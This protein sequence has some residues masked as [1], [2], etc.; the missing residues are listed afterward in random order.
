[1]SKKK[2]RKWYFLFLGLAWIGLLAPLSIWVGINFEKYIVQ[3]SGFSVTTG[4]ILAVLFVVLL[5]KYGIKKFGKV[6]WMTMLLMIV[7]CLNTIIVDALPLTFFTW[8]GALLYSVFE[9]PKNYFK[10]KLNVYVD[11]EIRTE[12]RNTTTENTETKAKAERRHTN[13]R[14]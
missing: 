11:E 12:A 9:V 3:K 1:M 14:F 13:G 2:F 5:L 6:F 8:L 7:Y 4:G 10:N